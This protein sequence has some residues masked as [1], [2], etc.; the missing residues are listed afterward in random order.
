MSEEKMLRQKLAIVD[1]YNQGK[2]FE[3]NHVIEEENIY[4]ERLGTALTIDLCDDSSDDRDY[5]LS[6]W[7]TFLNNESK[8]FF[9]FEQ[10]IKLVT[11]FSVYVR[12]NEL[13]TIIISFH[14]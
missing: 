1:Q 8:R 9:F 7:H 5:F 4:R 2:S 12:N 3:N 13:M 11:R 14:Q 6:D 10:K